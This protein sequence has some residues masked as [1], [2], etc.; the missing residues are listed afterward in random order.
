MSSLESIAA[1]IEKF[2]Q[3]M[4]ESAGACG[5][6]LGL[7]GGVDSALTA[8]LCSRALGSG[9]CLA[10]LLPNPA[11]T[12]TS[13]TEDGL[14]VAKKLGMPYKIIPIKDASDSITVHDTDAHTA[15]TIRQSVGNLNARLR[16]AIIYYEAQ[17]LNYLVAGTG[18]KSEHLIG[19]F[20]KYG[21]G[22][23]DMMPIADL[24]KTQVWELAEFLGV[25]HHI[26]EKAP[27]P[28]LW[29]DHTAADELGLDYSDIDRILKQLD[30][31]PHQ[32]SE[33]TG[34]QY[35]DIKNILALHHS[36]GHKRRMP[37]VPILDGS[38]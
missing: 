4:V 23:C 31:D 2:V 15:K 33:A 38:A 34:I 19:Y 1:Q 5:V 35:D 16:A 11:F 13:E 8:H 7:S 17:K 27:G 32:I 26:V 24:Y 28:H 3:E 10:L 25:P 36:T 30:A 21:D 18:D 29:P 22:A 12:P 6:A 37:P 14:L 20:T 9:R